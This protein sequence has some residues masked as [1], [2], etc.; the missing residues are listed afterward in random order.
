MMR[1]QKSTSLQFQKKKSFLKTNFKITAKFVN[2]SPSQSLNISKKALATFIGTSLQLKNE[3]K[4]QCQAS[5]ESTKMS[6]VRSGLGK[7]KL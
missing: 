3:K 6:H 4:K 7:L 5:H 2:S 1:F